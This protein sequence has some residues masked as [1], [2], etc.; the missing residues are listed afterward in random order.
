MTEAD[1][2]AV[3]ALWHEGWHDGHGAL[4]SEDVVIE[5][6]AD[7]FSMRLRALMADS[8]VAV[9]DDTIAAF[10]ALHDDEV[11]QFFVGR[12]FRGTGLAKLFLSVLEGALAAR[13]IEEVMIQCAAGNRRAHA[14]YA[15]AGYADTGIFDL[16]AWTSDGRISRFPTHIFRKTLIR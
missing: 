2:E 5:R 1:V 12:P 14:F 11:D 15:G 6:T 4:V 8:F 7:I 3:A 16:P 9:V 10:G 13:G